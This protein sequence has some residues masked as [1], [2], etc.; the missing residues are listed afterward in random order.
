MTKAGVIFLRALRVTLALACACPAFA[1][2]AA[3]DTVIQA[4]LSQ[5]RPELAE[6]TVADLEKAHAAKPTI[7]NSNDLGVA[8]L[9]TGKLD[10]AIALFRETEQKYPGNARVAANLGTALEFKGANEEALTWIREGVKRDATEHQGSEWLHARIL[11]AKIA[12]A[13]DPEWLGKNHVLDLDFGKG[14]IPAA[15]EILPVEQGRIKG[16]QQLLDQI[17]YQLDERTKFVKP[18]DP[19]VGDLYASAGDLAIAGA[20]SP[21]DDRRSRFRPEQ[22]YESA[23]RYGAPHADLIRRRLAKY[24]SDLAAL[25]PAPK[26][27][28]ADYPVVNKRFEKAPAQS[29]SLWIY[30]GAATLFT[31]V[32]VVAGVLIDRR[33]RKRAEAMPSAPLPDV[34]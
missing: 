24:Q 2:V 19:I 33:R 1:G 30:V 23:L 34:D 31:I 25:P 32:L 21:L 4:A 16:A 13:K 10:E 27:E 5:D 11:D 14:E 17:K 8:R 15:P 29:G 18:P 12:L 9:L 6:K 26:E 22:D 7:E 20:V 3:Y 28:V